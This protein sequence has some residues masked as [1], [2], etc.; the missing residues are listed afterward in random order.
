MSVRQKYLIPIA[1]CINGLMCALFVLKMLIWLPL[2]FP[3]LF[4]LD[5]EPVYVYGAWLI[6]IVNIYYYTSFGGYLIFRA[7]AHFMKT[8]SFKAA[9]NSWYI[10]GSAVFSE[11]L[12]IIIIRMTA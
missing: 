12:F 1:K 7:T 11:I 3:S 5:S 4:D 8:I 2:Y 6:M 9:K 10:F